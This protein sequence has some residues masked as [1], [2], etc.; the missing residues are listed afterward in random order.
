MTYL[1]KCR[2]QFEILHE[3]TIHYTRIFL[4]IENKQNRKRKWFV[5]GLHARPMSNAMI[6][7]S[8]IRM[9]VRKSLNTQIN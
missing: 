6:A 9:S 7:K 8:R 1:H 5:G 3:N 2:A 4:E